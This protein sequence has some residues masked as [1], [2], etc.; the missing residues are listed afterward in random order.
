MRCSRCVTARLSF[1]AVRLHVR[2]LLT[3]GSG[4]VFR[5]QIGLAATQALVSYL[6]QELSRTSVTPYVRKAA[7]SVISQ[8]CTKNPTGEARRCCFASGDV[9]VHWH[10]LRVR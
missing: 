3:A 6:H 4:R 7:L 8:L 1:A 2:A 9:P 10:V 5:W